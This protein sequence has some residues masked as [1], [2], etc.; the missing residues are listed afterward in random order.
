[1]GERK[2]HDRRE[3]EVFFFFFLV[4]VTFN[5]GFVAKGKGKRGN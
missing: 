4:V 3:K 1:M 5:M 2:V